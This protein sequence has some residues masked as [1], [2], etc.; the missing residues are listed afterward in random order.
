MLYNAR[1][2]MKSKYI[3]SIFAV[4]TCLMLFVPVFANVNLDAF[5]SGGKNDECEDAQTRSIEG[6][7][8]EVTYQAP[9]GQ[10]V[11]GVCIKSGTNMFGD[12]HSESLGN[13]TYENGCYEVSGVG[14][15]TVHVQRVGDGRYCQ[16]IS[17][18][19][20]YLTNGSSPSPSVSPSPSTNPTPSPEVSPSPSPR[21]GHKVNICHRTG[22]VTHPFE[23][24]N[25][26][27]HAFDGEGDN[28]H[29][30]HGDF[31]YFGP[32]DSNGH[33]TH[34]GNSW[35][36]EESC[37]AYGLNCPVTSPS[38]S[39]SI[40][41]SPSPSANPSPSPSP[42]GCGTVYID[43]SGNESCS[44]W[45]SPSPSPSVNA[46]P[47]P[48]PTPSPSPSASPCASCDEDED[49]DD[50]QTQTQTQTQTVNITVE[51]QVQ[52][53]KTPTELP[54]T[55]AGVLGL[56]TMASA[57][58]IGLALARFGR[59]FKVQGKKEE[60]LASFASELVKNRVQK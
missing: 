25:V 44:P 56:A 35:C 2:N 50:D 18:I 54:A 26:N 29:T 38:P 47:T 22:S 9:N 3:K 6:S 43:E 23:A 34:A 5:A 55:G 49:D 30:Q 45:P 51:G 33:P 52:G 17:H 10:T 32:V 58:P 46:S 27:E 31:L 40:N 42:S 11:S 4:I 37:R 15:S 13:G 41:P 28:D 20:V 59:G 7:E 48:A 12:T 39:P 21:N 14:T 36:A 53:A 8:N 16:G 57:A 1:L 24:I 19:D 60:N